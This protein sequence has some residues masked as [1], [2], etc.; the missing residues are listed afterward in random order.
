M[1]SGILLSW[2]R[3]ASY[4]QGLLE[5]ADRGL[6]SLALRRLVYAGTK[7]FFR[8]TQSS[9]ELTLTQACFS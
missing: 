2:K 7:A 4:R 3:W 9:K 8:L 5:R 6:V 1:R